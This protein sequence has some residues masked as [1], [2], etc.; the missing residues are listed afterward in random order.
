[1]AA[2]MKTTGDLRKFLSTL[3]VAVVQGETKAQEAAIA[4]K[5]IKE[6]NASLYSEIKTSEMQAAMGRESGKLGD[7]PLG[8]E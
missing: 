1:M 6:I 4:I 7:L 5:A 3:A 2:T 8:R